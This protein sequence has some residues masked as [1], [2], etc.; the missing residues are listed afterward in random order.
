MIHAWSK[1][2]YVYTG[3]KF[4]NNLGETILPFEALQTIPA[5]PKVNLP[6]RQKTLIAT[7]GTV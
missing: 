4:K 7:L 2:G 5:V 3:N 1:G 6:S